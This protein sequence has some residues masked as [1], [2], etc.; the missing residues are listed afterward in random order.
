MS[1]GRIC[2]REVHLAAPQEPVRDAARR[3]L[4]RNVGSLIVIDGDRRPIGMLTD[5]DLA[6]RVVANERDP[7][8][9]TVEHV[10]TS[11]PRTIAEETPVDRALWLMRAWGVRRAPVVDVAGHLAGVLALDDVV[12]LI[13]GELHVATQLLAKQFPPQLDLVD[14]PVAS[15]SDAR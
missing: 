13:A 1:V 9:S 2:T 5:R 11:L 3:M 14:E 7:R 4:E 12:T 8:S 10:M 15:A 6:L